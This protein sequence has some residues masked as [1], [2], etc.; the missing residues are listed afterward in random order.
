MPWL[1]RH[2][3]L[4][5]L[6]EKWHQGG[7][8]HCWKEKVPDSCHRMSNL[9]AMVL[10]NPTALGLCAQPVW[11]CQKASVTGSHTESILFLKNSS[12]FMFL[13]AVLFSLLL[14]WACQYPSVPECHTDL[15]LKTARLFNRS[16]LYK[17]IFFTKK[18]E[19]EKL[20][21]NDPALTKCHAETVLMPPLGDGSSDRRGLMPTWLFH[22]WVRKHVFFLRRI[23]KSKCCIFSFFIVCLSI[24]VKGWCEQRSRVFI[25]V[26]IESWLASKSILA[27]EGE[28]ILK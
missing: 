24:K 10:L 6:I 8:F 7:I 5:F 9:W 20:S 27:D 26:V 23:K 2:R 14:F 4:H 22:C 16:Q 15:K 28:G 12:N 25:Q 1:T 11:A 17:E 21:N 13:F 19:S 18:K 3:Q